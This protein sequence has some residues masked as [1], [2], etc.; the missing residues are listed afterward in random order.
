MSIDLSKKVTV[1]VGPN[2]SGKSSILKGLLAF[3]QTYDDHTDHTGFVARGDYVDIGPFEEY[4][5]GHDL[6]SKCEFVF[7]INP[8]LTRVAFTSVIRSNLNVSTIFVE[9]IQENDPQTKHAR[10]SK[11]NVYFSGKSDEVNID[12]YET[13]NYFIKFDRVR[14][15]DEA[16][17]I[18]L[19][20]PLY[21]ILPALGV[22]KPTYRRFEQAAVNSKL[23][24]TRENQSGMTA[25]YGK[26]VSEDV[27]GVIWYLERYCLAPVHEAL[28]KS[29]TRQIFALGPLRQPPSRSVVRTDE[30]Q[31]VGS[32]GQNATSV[33]LDLHQR[34]VKQGG[35]GTRAKD[36]FERLESW[37]KR[38]KLSEN[39]EVSSWRDLVDM[40]TKS[41]QGY[42]MGDSIVDIGV[43]FSQASPILIQLAAMPDRSMLIAEQPELHLYPWAQTR[44]GEILCEEAFRGNKNLIIETHSEHILLGIQLHISNSRVNGHGLKPED[45]QILYVSRDAGISDLKIDEYGEFSSEWPPGFFDQTLSVYQRILENRLRI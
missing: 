31:K 29:F 43:G 4:V 25:V 26:G 30:R 16:F 41:D 37:F 2:S 42:K 38:L 3:K 21:E 15:S 40:R 33:Y 34:A 1:L 45:V 14:G 39:I 17:K 5:M 9:M 22:E 18:S 23:R 28:T 19:S 27:M 20:E 10:I 11:Y 24:F 13:S 7:R 32:Q 35:K 6:K 8:V 36:V 44:L 12:N